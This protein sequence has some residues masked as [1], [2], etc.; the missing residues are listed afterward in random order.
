VVA[1]VAAA[2][3]SA[4]AALLEGETET[5]QQAPQARN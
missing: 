5:E 4:A 2:T 3:D 1:V